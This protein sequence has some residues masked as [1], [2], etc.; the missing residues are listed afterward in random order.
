METNTP[1]KP[2][3]KKLTAWSLT[4]IMGMLFMLVRC[5]REVQ[6]V[7]TITLGGGGN[8]EEEPPPPPADQIQSTE[9]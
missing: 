2:G 7:P 4:L 6:G 1:F 9:L 8:M 3:G 5:D